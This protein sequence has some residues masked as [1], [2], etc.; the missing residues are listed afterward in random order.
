M[1]VSIIGTSIAPVSASADPLSDKKAQAAALAE[2]INA[3]GRQVEVLAEQF[4]GAQ[5]HQ[6][7]VEQQ[8]A[9]A[10]QRFGVAQAQAE[11]NRVALNQEA[12]TAYVHGGVLSRPSMVGYEGAADIAVAKGY[13]NIATSSQVD[14]LDRMRQAEQQLRQQQA[15]LLNAQHDSQLALSQVASRKQ[16]VEQAAGAASA[17]LNQVQGDLATLVAQ[18]QAVIA[19]QQVAQAKAAMDAAQA[20]QQR[21]QAAAPAPSRSAAA[22]SANALVAGILPPNSGGPVSPPT[23]VRAPPPVKASGGAGAALAYA[24]AQLG[25]PYL[26]AGAGPDSF[27]CSGLTMR[28][29]GA[30]GVSLPHSAAAQY[31][32]TAHIAI[33]DLQPGDLVFFG[34]DLSHVGIYVGNGSMIHAPHSGAV[35]SYS[36]IYWPDLRPFGGRP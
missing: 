29:W 33:A 8:L 34:S 6:T 16:A 10:Q 31:A 17:T 27:D 19:A 13:F 28:A 35:V 11:K 9:D 22:P 21:L 20:R 14:A 15:A 36:T 18:Q 23:T 26:W 32:N 1:I 12:V 30:A 2:K 25:K 24:Q 4:N 5:L 7:Q 3:Q